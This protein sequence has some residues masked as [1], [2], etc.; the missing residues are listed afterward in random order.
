VGACGTTGEWQSAT[1]TLDG[2]EVALTGRFLRSNAF[3]GFDTFNQPFVGFEFQDGGGDLFGQIT[4]R[5]LGSQIA[6][7]LDNELLSAP[8]VQGV[9]TDSGQITGLTLDRAR[10]L[11]V[12]LNAGAL[13]LLLSVLAEQ[14]VDATLGQDSVDQSVLAGQIGL[15]LVALYMVLYYRLPGVISVAALIVYTVL[16]LA[17][18]KLIPVTLT[19]AGIG[20]FVLSIGM[21]VDAN[22]LIFERMKE[23]LRAGRSYAASVDAGFSRAWA[24]IR[25]SNVATLITCLILFVMG[26]G[27]EL[28]LFGALDAPLVQGFAVTLALGVMISMF[29][30]LVVSRTFMRLFIGTRFAR[31]IDWWIADPPVAPP[32]GPPSTRREE[33]NA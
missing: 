13:P 17:V 24:S 6:I 19:L 21:A 30:A 14:T 29:S 31:R 1:G 8:Q 15:L 25:D 16:T 10:E 5:S 33:A 11:V 9:I 18:F 7:F 27:I 4:Q 22:I 23:E 2:D 26:G 28:P 20:A 3:V 32:P 12:Q